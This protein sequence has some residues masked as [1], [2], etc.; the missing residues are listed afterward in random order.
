MPPRKA[1]SK[2]TGA[3]AQ[4]ASASASTR[5]STSTSP[6]ARLDRLPAELYLLILR[7]LSKRDGANLALVCK[8]LQDVGE[9]LVW[10]RV[11]LALGKSWDEEFLEQLD[12]GDDLESVRT[13]AKDQAEDAISRRK[14][15]SHWVPSSP[16]ASWEDHCARMTDRVT[17]VEQA[18]K[19]RPERARHVRRLVF[20]PSP[21]LMARSKKIVAAVWG[22]LEHLEVESCG[23]L[24]AG[25]RSAMACI[26]KMYDMFAKMGVGMCLGLRTLDV[27]LVGDHSQI[28]DQLSTLL[29]LAPSLTTLNLQAP[30]EWT[31]PPNHLISKK[32]KTLTRFHHL[33]SITW[34][35]NYSQLAVYVD[36]LVKRSPELT[37]FK[38]ENQLNVPDL[39][40]PAVVKELAKSKSLRRLVWDNRDDLSPRK[41]PLRKGAFKNLEELVRMDDLPF[42]EYTMIEVSTQSTQSTQRTSTDLITRSYP[43][44]RPTLNPDPNPNSIRGVVWTTDDSEYDSQCGPALTRR[45]PSSSSRFLR[46]PLCAPS[47]S[48]SVPASGRCASRYPTLSR[49]VL[50]T[51]KSSSGCSR[52]LVSS[53]SSSVSRTRPD[54]IRTSRHGATSGSTGSSSVR[55]VTPVTVVQMGTTMVRVRVRQIRTD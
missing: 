16:L 36:N 7:H 38:I 3:A 46:S 13:R 23:V 10:R 43:P 12:F 24:A 34:C 50:S 6:N 17:K 40:F 30:T 41:H 20:E 18:F 31:E 26:K 8:S 49:T 37:T 1:K 55:T 29:Y 51:L 39:P 9:S 11:S 4:A 27:K 25:Q 44:P 45:H 19:S 53:S 54:S 14:E 47:F 22:N 42:E 52:R 35:R 48:L 28:D 32:W 5:T 21:H 2:K 33:E 15:R